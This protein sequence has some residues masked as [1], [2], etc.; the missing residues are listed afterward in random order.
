MEDGYKKHGKN[1]GPNRSK[2]LRR[3]VKKYTGKL[4]RQSLNDP[5]NQG[6]SFN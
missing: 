4:S 5:D 2:I 3:G 1:Y 6:W